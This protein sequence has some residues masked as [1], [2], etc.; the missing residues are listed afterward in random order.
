M[1]RVDLGKNSD[2]LINLEGARL[3]R[4]T[5]R[6][7]KFSVTFLLKNS[8]ESH[9]RSYL[10]ENLTEM[11]LADSTRWLELR[12]NDMRGFIDGNNFTH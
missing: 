12:S 2:D 1:F 4:G 11:H 10:G 6:A 5:D 9:F 7:F 8:A 3:L